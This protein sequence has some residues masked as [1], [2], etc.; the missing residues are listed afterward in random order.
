MSQKFLALRIH[1]QTSKDLFSI[2][3][4]RSQG[5]TIMSRST[6][7]LLNHGKTAYILPN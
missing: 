1:D 5:Y 3:G 7:K 4:H 6:T 2:E